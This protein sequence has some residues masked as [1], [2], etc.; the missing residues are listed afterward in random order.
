MGGQ[1]GAGL[2]DDRLGVLL[3]E[4]LECVVAFQGLPNGVGL[5]AG[6]MTG[7]V[8]AI[9]P[10]LKLVVR[11]IGTG[12]HEGEFAPLHVFDLGDLLGELSRVHMS[13]IL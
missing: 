6:D 5:I 11:T 13:N 7:D 10:C 1:F 8:L 3:G 4:V 2:I 12:G 9:L